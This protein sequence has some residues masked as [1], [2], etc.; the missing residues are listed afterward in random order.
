MIACPIVTTE[1]TIEASSGTDRTW[2]AEVVSRITAWP[3]EPTRHHD[4]DPARIHIIDVR[5]DGQP[6]TG[7]IRGT[8][9]A[10]ITRPAI[11]DA[12]LAE[13]KRLEEVAE[14]DAKMGGV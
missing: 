6:L 5:L 1:H 7:P 10:T 3:S 14:A 2:H 13:V 8:V 9:I 12:A 4:G 11:I